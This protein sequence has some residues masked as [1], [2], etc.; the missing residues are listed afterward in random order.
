MDYVI[1]KLT[2]FNK[3]II[4][5]YIEREPLVAIDCTVG[6]GSDIL[7]LCKNLTKDAVVTGFD[8]Q[9]PAL[10]NTEEVLKEKGL[11]NYK[12]IHD[13]HENIDNY[14]KEESADIIVYN[15]G[16]LPKYD[17]NITTLV[18]TTLISIKKALS[19]IKQRGIIS[20]AAYPGHSEG[21]KEKEA[22]DQ[23][24][25]TID[26]KIYHVL[27]CEYINQ[28]NTPPLLYYIERK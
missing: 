14:F 1:K 18:D 7:Y 21:S 26:P 11:I 3:T 12:L 22:L 13:G 19:I 28:A 10:D 23:F 9:K 16:Y 25:S 27:K 2:S 15:L 24:L 8:I 4:D 17:K 5:R 6:N 20:I